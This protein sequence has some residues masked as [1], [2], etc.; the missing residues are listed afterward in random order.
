MVLVIPKS[1]PWCRLGAIELK[2]L[3]KGR[4]IS[5]E[6]GSGTLRSFQKLLARKGYATNKL[7][8]VTM[9]L[10]STAAVKEALIAG[11]GVSILS[12]T[13]V[14]R[15]IQDGSLKALPIRGLRLERDFYQVYHRHRTLSPVSQAFL[16]FLKQHS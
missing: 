16:H 12:R 5:R 8:N 10:G 3:H 13:A 6:G 4:F 9:E 11:M 14:R 1:H 2:D 7:L 15:E